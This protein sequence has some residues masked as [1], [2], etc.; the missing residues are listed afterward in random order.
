MRTSPVPSSVPRR[1]SS[2]HVV[3]ALAAVLAACAPASAP[4]PVKPVDPVS[5]ADVV[6]RM[7]ARW[8]GRWFRTLAFTQQNTRWARDGS[9]SASTWF[10]WLQVPGRLRI[11]FL[12]APRTGSAAGVPVP[13]NGAIYADGRVTSIAGGRA[14]RS[15]EQLNILLLLTADVY[16]QPVAESV[17]QL[18]TLGVDLTTVRRD[19]VETRPVWVVGARKG[20]RTS[21]QFWIDAER[22]VALRVVERGAAVQGRPATSTEYQLR[23]YRDVDGVPVV[24]EITFVRDGQRVFRERYT[25]VRLNERFD[26]LLFVPSA[27]GRARR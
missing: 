6:A 18:T 21:P 24:H 16:G 1:A 11:E 27:W 23:D 19:T 13:E 3:L 15:E 17:K 12:P 25:A 10:E 5:G 14:A 9:E 4:R 22:W 2:R 7:V 20:D 26:S 8:D